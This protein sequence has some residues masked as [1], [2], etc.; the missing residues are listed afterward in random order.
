M[1]WQTDVIIQTF[2]GP[3]SFLIKS[4]EVVLFTGPNGVGKSALIHQIFRSIGPTK[5]ELFP[6][7]RQIHFQSDD[8]ET[9]GQTVDALTTMRFTNADNANRLRDAWSEF[10]LKSV[11]KDA[12]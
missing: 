5:A 3:L 4:G 9:I 1:T 11:V 6:G 12:S 7:H 2:G 10:H 8:V